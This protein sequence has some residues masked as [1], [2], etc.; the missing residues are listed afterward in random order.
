MRMRL[1]PSKRVRLSLSEITVDKTPKA[2]QQSPGPVKHYPTGIYLEEEEE[3]EE[4]CSLSSSPHS[5]RPRTCLPG[6]W[7]RR[8]RGFSACCF[9]R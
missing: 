2:I 8:Q 6:S 7:A 3:E 9:T 5:Y 4:V 1:Q